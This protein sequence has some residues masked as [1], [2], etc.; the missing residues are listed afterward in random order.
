LFVQNL[1]E[2]KDLED[3][4]VYYLL[5]AKFGV[6]TYEAYLSWCKEAKEELIKYV[7]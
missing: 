4:H 7:C 2:I 5:T 6:K 1:E 3:A